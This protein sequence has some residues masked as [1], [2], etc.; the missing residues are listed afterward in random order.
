[1]LARLSSLVDMVYP[2][3]CAGCRVLT[4]APHG[5]CATCWSGTSFITGPACDLCGMPVPSALPGHR[6]VCEG[7]DARP[8]GWDQGRAA[9]LYEGIGRQVLLRLKHGDRLDLARPV[10]RW[11]ARAG[12]PLIDA[13]EV[14]APV[15]LHWTR[16]AR[17]RYNQAAELAR[18][19]ALNAG[20]R[21]VPD[22]LRRTRATPRQVAM[23][24]EARFALQRD[25]FDLPG[26]N[27]A[28]VRGRHVLLI[29]DV[30]TSGA[31]LAACTQALRGAGAS[32]V[33]VLVAARVAQDE[34]ASI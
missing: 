33:S 7:C 15:P 23:D 12:A 27:A 26:R 2:P 32:R 25:A 9:V 4:E 34:F 14:I 18:Q 1:M 17:R 5:L 13:A 3:E 20:N 24:R 11:M 21:L 29:D 16:L 28:K 19:P 30:M 10:A 8:H 6:V 31:T 22:L